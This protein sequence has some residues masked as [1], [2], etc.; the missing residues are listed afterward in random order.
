[1]M[2]DNYILNTDHYMVNICTNKM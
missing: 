2:I 1:M